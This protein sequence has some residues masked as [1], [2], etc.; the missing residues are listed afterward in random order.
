MPVFVVIVFIIQQVVAGKVLMALAIILGGFWL[1]GLLWARSLAENLRIERNHKYGWSQ[2][3]D[4]FEETV[5]LKNEGVFPASWLLIEDHSTLVGHSISLGTG[6]GGRSSRHW[7]RRTACTQRGEF[8]LGPTSLI[9][10]DPFGIYKVRIDT[11]EKYD[12]LVSPPVIPLPQQIE[13]ST[14]FLMDDRRSTHRKAE[15]SNVSVSTRLF[16][17][18]DSLMRIHWLTTAREDQPYVRQFE[19]IHASNHC[20]IVLDLDWAV[21]DLVGEQNSL[22]QG[23]ILGVSLANRFLMSGVAVG[24]LAQGDHFLMLPPGKGFD[25]FRRIQKLMATVQNGDQPLKQFL[26][27]TWTRLNDAA[28]VVFVT[29]SKDPG[30]LDSLILLRNA[31]ISASVFVLPTE[32]DT[33][34][35]VEG[36]SRLISRSGVDSHIVPRSLFEVPESAPGRHGVIDWKFTPLGRAIKIVG[37]GRG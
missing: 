37:E 35:L 15:S 1:V 34:G 8:Q 33:P 17:P 31:Q 29:P 27:H 24:L 22:E 11:Q 3:G 30:W 6:I 16:A 32:Q 10:G 25:Q 19:N 14:G 20:W 23:I 21:H 12:F 18:G 4:V 2:V 28:N 5:T 9:S 36:F 13:I 7:T 26:M